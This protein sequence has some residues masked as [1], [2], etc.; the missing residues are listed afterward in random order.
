MCGRFA[1]YQGLAD[2]L[3]ELNS[4]R[5]VI[6]GYDNVPIA[7]Y[8]VAP[9]TRVQLL[10][11]DDDGLHVDPIVWGWAPHWATG[12]RPPPIN[13]RLE[14]VATGNFFRGIWK[15]GRALVPSDGWYEWARREVACV[16]VRRSPPA[17][18]AV[19]SAVP[20]EVWRVGN[21]PSRSPLTMQPPPN[22][23]CQNRE[24]KAC[25]R[26]S[27]RVGAR[28]GGKVSKCESHFTIVN[29]EGSKDAD[30]ARIAVG[31]GAPFSPVM[32]IMTAGS[33]EKP[34][35]LGSY[36]WN[37]VS[38][39]GSRKG[40]LAVR[41]GDGHVGRGSGKKRMLRCNGVDTGFNVT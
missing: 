16:I 2:Y 22:S 35:P 6:S 11:L 25:L 33:Q 5:D 15:T 32:G 19:P 34:K 4:E 26:A 7:R 28:V 3:T 24:R 12:Q 18:P 41:R 37:T 23:G 14:T 40:N 10:H 31:T 38:P 8:N 30:R 36:T 1:Q 20:Y 27:T 17:R 29:Q 39:Y 9:S 13:A 21:K